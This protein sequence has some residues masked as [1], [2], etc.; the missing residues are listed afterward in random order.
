MLGHL[1]ALRDDRCIAADAGS[2]G[3]TSLPVPACCT[4][5]SR[6]CWY[7]AAVL[8]RHLWARR[9][10]DPSEI[11]SD[12]RAGC[13]R[14]HVVNRVSSIAYHVSH[15]PGSRCICCSLDTA[16]RI[17]RARFGAASCNADQTVPWS[18][19]H[20]EHAGAA[21]VGLCGPDIV[22]VRVSL[23]RRARPRASLFRPRRWFDSPAPARH[24]SQQPCLV[25]ISY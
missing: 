6:V 9:L 4:L 25:V 1:R 19:L 23:Q 2:L 3:C 14:H 24:S 10:T 17:T 12:C 21:L 11:G 8:L 15:M 22:R 20:Q 13:A 16:A 7:E 5:A 18:R